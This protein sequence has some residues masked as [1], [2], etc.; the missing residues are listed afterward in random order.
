[1]VLASLTVPEI[2]RE[3]I[4]APMA[5]ATTNKPIARPTMSSSKAYA[6]LPFGGMLFFVRKG[7]IRLVR[8]ASFFEI[9]HHLLH[10]Q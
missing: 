5:T 1:M 8:S 2:P 7:Q 4:N 10:E 3:A 6:A 9:T